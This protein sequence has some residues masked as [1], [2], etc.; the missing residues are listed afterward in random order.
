MIMAAG[1]EGFRLSQYKWEG[2]ANLE[3][4][5]T[6]GINPVI[7]LVD[8]LDDMEDKDN[9]SDNHVT[10]LILN[11]LKCKLEDLEQTVYRFIDEMHED[12]KASE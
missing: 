3:E 8:I 7:A 9:L 4:L 2:G 1:L 11:D 6:W 12:K 10:C 5:V